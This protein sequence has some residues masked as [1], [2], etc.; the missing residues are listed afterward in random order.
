MARKRKKT[1]ERENEWA[2][3]SPTLNKEKCANNVSTLQHNRKA[4]SDHRLASISLVCDSQVSS[5]DLNAR[6]ENRKALERTR[7]VETSAVDQTRVVT[8]LLYSLLLLFLHA[9]QFN[10]PLQLCS[11]ASFGFQFGFRLSCRLHSWL[12]VCKFGRSWI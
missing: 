4:F 9:N 12:K 10:G 2:N 5:W 6:R 1:R 11:F 7:N 8:R 3:K